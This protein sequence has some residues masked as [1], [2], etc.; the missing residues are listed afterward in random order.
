MLSGALA[1][2]RITF[3][4]L[5]TPF[6]VVLIQGKFSVVLSTANNIYPTTVLNIH[7]EY[8]QKNVRNDT[9]LIFLLA[10]ACG[11]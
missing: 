1:V 7:I 3:S 2:N 5:E 6:V 11:H 10:I 9:L 8:T 4:I